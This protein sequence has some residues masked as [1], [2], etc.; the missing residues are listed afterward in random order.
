MNEHSVNKT[1]KYA[2]RLFKI[3]YLYMVF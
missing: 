1:N 3:E 2:G